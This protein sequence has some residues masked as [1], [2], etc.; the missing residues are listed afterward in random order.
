MNNTWAYI[1]PLAILMLLIGY[2]RIEKR[3]K[4]QKPVYRTTIITGRC[5]LMLSL[6]NISEPTRPY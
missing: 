6:I 3:I 4:I 5:L 1:V 2:V